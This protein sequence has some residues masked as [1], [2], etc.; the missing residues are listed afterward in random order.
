MLK[1]CKALS[2]QG[3]EVLLTGRRLGQKEDDEI[4]GFYGLPP[5]FNLHLRRVA[6]LIDNRV[7]RLI[8]LAGFALALRFRLAVRKFKPE[9]VYSRLTN[10]ELL[11]LP[12]NLPLIY[13]MHSP[14]ALGDSGW[15]GWLF[16]HL[17]S[18]LNVQHIVVTTESLRKYLRAE[19]PD[20]EVRVAR[21]SAE[22]PLVLEEAQV[23]DFRQKKIKGQTFLFHAGY[24]GFLGETRG[25][26]T[27]IETAVRTPEVAFHIV[28]GTPDAVGY[29]QNVAVDHKVPDNVFFYGHRPADE[30]PWFLH[31]FD[32]FLAPLQRPEKPFTAM[33][34]LKIPQYLAYGKPIIAS[35][36]NAHTEQLQDEYT[37]LL[38]D[39]EAPA[40]WSDALK[41]LQ[42][43]SNLC[44]RLGENAKRLYNAELT[45]DRRLALILDGVV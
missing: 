19:M 25:T 22:P 35:K 9:L 15:R 20:L 38:V 34:P 3:H 12:K 4:F 29:W 10:A 11:A 42:K 41:R 18:R 23:A 2:D 36:V 1:V 33:S 39:P 31:S 26:R 28:G 45:P 43:N 24:T 17:I 16:R 21:L 6:R 37:A 40:A 30:M 27:L 13:E 5:E 14:G 32:V 8:D 44:E 7:A